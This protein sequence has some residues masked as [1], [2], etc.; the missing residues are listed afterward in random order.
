MVT[1]KILFVMLINRICLSEKILSMKCLNDMYQWHA[2]MSITSKC[3]NDMYQ[4][5]DGMSI[6]STCWSIARGEGGDMVHPLTKPSVHGLNS[7]ASQSNNGGSAPSPRLIY[8]RCGFD[9]M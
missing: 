1:K 8:E 2:G 7:K 4:W 3:W 9:S 6:A 5:Q